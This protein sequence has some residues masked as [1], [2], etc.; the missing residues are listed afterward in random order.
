MCVCVCVCARANVSA[1]SI[2]LSKPRRSLRSRMRCDG[3]GKLD[4]HAAGASPTATQQQ[5]I[6]NNNNNNNNNNKRHEAASVARAAAA[7]RSNPF[8]LMVGEWFWWCQNQ[9][10]P[11]RTRCNQVGHGAA[12]RIAPFV[13][14]PAS[15]RPR[16]SQST[17]TAKK[18]FQWKWK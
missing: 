17:E 4:G 1:I 2:G 16:H 7:T 9:G 8:N 10:R 11:Y 5:N 15:T 18:G 6:N 13:S 12:N 14:G 3:R